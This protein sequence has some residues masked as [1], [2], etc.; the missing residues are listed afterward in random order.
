MV[1]DQIVKF[2]KSF[3][4]GVIGRK[5]SRN[6]C[7]MVCLPLTTLLCLNGVACKLVEGEV[8]TISLC[9]NH[10]WIELADGR[11]LD[12]TADQFNKYSEFPELPKVYLGPPSVIHLGVNSTPS[13]YMSNG[14]LFA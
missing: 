3:R 8:E 4:N 1:D 9:C 7:Y 13:T 5:S 6:M 10:F 2:A 14:A 12:P 11:I